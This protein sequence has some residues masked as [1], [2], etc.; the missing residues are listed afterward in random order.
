VVP[1][2]MIV[3]FHEGSLYEL[4]ARLPLY[5]YGNTIIKPHKIMV[6]KMLNLPVLRG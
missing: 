4:K 2:G 1:I 3:S 5:S 6:L